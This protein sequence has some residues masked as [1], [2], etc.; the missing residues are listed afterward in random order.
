MREYI[1]AGVLKL[2]EPMVM[3]LD[4]FNRKPVDYEENHGLLPLVAAM[5]NR[6]FEATLALVRAGAVA[7]TDFA[8]HLLPGALDGATDPHQVGFEL[9]ARRQWGDLVHAHA[10]INEA[11]MSWRIQLALASGPGQD[12]VSTPSAASAPRRRAG[13]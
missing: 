6:N 1:D 3:K 4:Y 8:G 12:S 7:V 10:R 2:D 9:Y 13:M 11:I 5:N